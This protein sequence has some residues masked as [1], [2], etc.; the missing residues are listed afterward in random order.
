MRHQIHDN[1]LEWNKNS[2]RVGFFWWV[3]A[4]RVSFNILANGENLNNSF[5]IFIEQYIFA[6]TYNAIHTAQH[7]T[8]HQYPVDR[9][10]LTKIFFKYDSL[11][12]K[13][14]IWIHLRKNRNKKSILNGGFHEYFTFWKS[15]WFVNWWHSQL[16]LNVAV[17]VTCV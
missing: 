14:N 2:M 12:Q 7:S 6:T 13:L 1:R 4:M 15:Y 17:I 3:C 11:H 8:K 5:Y 16:T 9:G 10:F